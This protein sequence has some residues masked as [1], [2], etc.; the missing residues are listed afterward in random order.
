MALQVS[1]T[2]SNVGK[3]IVNAAKIATES[4]ATRF[5]MAVGQ[6]EAVCAALT[7]KIGI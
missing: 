5:C 7:W 1:D 4:A 2:L 3:N 6:V